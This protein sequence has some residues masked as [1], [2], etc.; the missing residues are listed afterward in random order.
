MRFPSDEE[1]FGLIPQ[2]NG[3]YLAG[4]IDPAKFNIEGETLLDA[5]NQGLR[6]AFEKMPTKYHEKKVT[7]PSW[8][9]YKEYDFSHEIDMDIAEFKSLA[10]R[11]VDAQIDY[12]LDRTNGRI[13][14]FPPFSH[15]AGKCGNRDINYS[16]VKAPD[17]HP[18]LPQYI[19]DLYNTYNKLNP[20]ARVNIKKYR[21]YTLF[22]ALLALVYY[23]AIILLRPVIGDFPVAVT[24]GIA[25]AMSFVGTWLPYKGLHNFLS[26][27]QSII[28]F[29][30]LM[31]ITNIGLMCLA[32]LE[33]EESIFRYVTYFIVVYGI[34]VFMA[35]L[36]QWIVK[37]VS[38]IKFTKTKQPQLAEAFADLM[39]KYA[40]RLHRY[41]RLRKLWCSYEGASC[42]AWLENQQNRL[43]MYS[44]EYDSIK[45]SH[46]I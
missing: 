6:S 32:D 26:F 31:F 3:K 11:Q 30:A 41:I 22:A 5:Y 12:H 33:W 2:K 19:Q 25:L 9:E 42:P 15:R 35:H 18:V 24:F 23:F 16:H 13:G 14:I 17:S 4:N 7:F 27:G 45:E 38:L 1:L 21:L 36:I 39:D 43:Q 46:K 28:L 29:L 34:I 10:F 40:V 8:A 20:D 44:K 37:E